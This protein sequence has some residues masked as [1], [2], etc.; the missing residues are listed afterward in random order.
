MSLVHM[1]SESKKKTCALFQ[2]KA[3]VLFLT[4]EEQGSGNNL[5]FHDQMLNV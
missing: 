2:D 4:K 3:I 5:L 1:Y